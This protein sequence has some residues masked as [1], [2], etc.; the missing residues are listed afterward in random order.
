MTKRAKKAGRSLIDY[1]MAKKRAA[2]VICSL[3]NEIK[4]Q[5]REARNRKIRL[6]EQIE[7]LAEEQGIKLTRA[8]FDAH[9]SGRHEVQ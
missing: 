7:W 2:C 3:P 1:T 8:Q 6:P 9:Y 5:L 4:S